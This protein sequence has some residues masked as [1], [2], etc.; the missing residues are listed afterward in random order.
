M[1][2]FQQIIVIK[3]MI[4]SEGLDIQIVACPIVRDDDGLAM[5]SRN[6]LL[7]RKERIAAPEIYA[8]LRRSVDYAASHSVEETRRFVEETLNAVPGF[9][10]EYFSIVD[11][12][13]LIPI[14]EWD[15][16]RFV[17]GCITVYVGKIRLIDNIF[18]KGEIQ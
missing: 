3:N 10:V 11:G 14:E 16:S 6:L 9:N 17:V 15:E 18:Y 8:T 12:E 4:A 5:S 2:D 7:E 13:S 1:K